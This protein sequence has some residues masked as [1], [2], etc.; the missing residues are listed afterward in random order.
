LRRDGEAAAVQTDASRVKLLRAFVAQRR[1]LNDTWYGFTV[2]F[3]AL[4]AD[5]AIRFPA[6]VEAYVGRI[7]AEF[8][9]PQ[10]ASKRNG[11]AGV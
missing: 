7:S 10:P 8:F 11:R 3:Y 1:E 6:K 4:L 9:K 5:P 2:E